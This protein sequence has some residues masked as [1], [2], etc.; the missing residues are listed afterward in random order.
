MSKR[1]LRNDDLNFA[2]DKVNK[3]HSFKR[4]GHSSFYRDKKKSV[5]YKLGKPARRCIHRF[6]ERDD[7]NCESKV[8]TSLKL[9]M[10]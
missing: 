7:P 2:R 4:L 8:R 5:L 3:A 1:D 6:K 10:S 9:G